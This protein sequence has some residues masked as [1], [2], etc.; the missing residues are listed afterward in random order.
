M[1]AGSVCVHTCVCVCGYVTG[2]ETRHRVCVC[3]RAHVVSVVPSLGVVAQCPAHP[4]SQSRVE[5]AA[6]PSTS[7]E[8]FFGGNGC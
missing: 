2:G 1:S 3:A 7:S 5:A 6:G 4:L 8:F